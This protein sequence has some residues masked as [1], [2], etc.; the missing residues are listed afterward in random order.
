MGRS[1]STISDATVVAYREF[2]PDESYYRQGWDE[3]A[4]AGWVDPETDSF[5]DWMWD[6]WNDGDAANEWDGILS[7]VRDYLA[8][9]WP[10]L[11]EAEGWVG[12]EVHVIAENSHTVVGISEYCGLISISLAPRYDRDDNALGEQ[13]RKSISDKF[14]TSFGEYRKVGTA[15][16][17]ESFYEREV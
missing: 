17:G 11:R 10:S 13:W 1:V 7:W 8:E 14:L 6:Q 16:N 12:N 3:Y 5:E 2:G 9:L 4:E 15:S